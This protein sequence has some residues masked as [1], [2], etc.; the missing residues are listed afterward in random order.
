MNFSK[1]K[2]GKDYVV[3]FEC[4]YFVRRQMKISA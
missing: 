3:K 1:T 4:S 2:K